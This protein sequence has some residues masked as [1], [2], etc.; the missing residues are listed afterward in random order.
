MTHPLVLRLQTLAKSNYTLFPV[1]RNPATREGGTNHLQR[2]YP[3]N[4]H[5]Q[6]ALNAFN[7]FQLDAFP[8]TPSSGFPP[9]QKQ[10][11]CHC[12]RCI[13]CNIVRPRCCAWSDVGAKAGESNRANDGFAGLMG[14]MAPHVVAVKATK[15]SLIDRQR[16]MVVYEPCSE[17]LNEMLFRRTRLLAL[18]QPTENATLIY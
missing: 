10:F 3:S 11:L 1:S 6:S 12:R 17:H 9:K 14:T 7:I 18:A 15:Y 13:C 4:P 2:P 8:P 5:L 16:T